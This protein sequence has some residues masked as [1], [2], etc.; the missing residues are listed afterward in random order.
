MMNLRVKDIRT[1]FENCLRD[2]KFTTDKTGVKTLELSGVSFIADQPAIFGSPD[3]SY[4]ER[5]IAW[6]L[7]QSLYVKDIGEPVPKIWLQVADSFGKINSNYGFLVHSPANGD[8][9][10]NT[11]SELIA[12][13]YSRRAVMIYTRPSMHAEACQNG[14]SDFICTNAVQYLIRDGRCDVVV[15]MRSNDAF[16]GYRNDVAWQKYVQ[17][18]LVR[19]YNEQTSSDIIPG[20]IFWQVGSLHLY[21]RHF[22]LIQL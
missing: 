17:D 19:D 18:S 15:Q 4:I 12:N 10:K 16:F 20:D 22:K 6:Y 8:Q 7:S 5:E 3:Q 9:Y 21:E 13:P 14:M 11:L 1:L 2:E